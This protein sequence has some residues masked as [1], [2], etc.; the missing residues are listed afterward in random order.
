[1][2]GGRGVITGMAHIT[3]GGIVDN[4]PRMLP[5]GLGARFDP[6]AWTVPP[7]FELIRRW[8]EVEAAEMYRVFNMGLGFVLSCRPADAERVRALVPEAL[9]VGEVVAL[10]GE[11]A[12]PPAGRVELDGLDLA[13]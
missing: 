8:G 13:C 3:G 5:A 12:N 11:G 2:E 10:P 6:R 1:S 4:V 7:I 9:P